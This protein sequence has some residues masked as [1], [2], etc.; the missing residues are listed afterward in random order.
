MRRVDEGKHSAFEENKSMFN[1][2]LDQI[3]IHTAVALTLHSC[4]R[5]SS[6]I[7]CAQSD[8]RVISHT[9]T[10]ICSMFRGAYEKCHR[11]TATNTTKH[12]KWTRI[13]RLNRANYVCAIFC[14]LLYMYMGVSVNEE[15]EKNMRNCQGEPFVFRLRTCESQ[16]FCV[17]LFSS[18]QSFCYLVKQMACRSRIRYLNLI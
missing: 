12:E 9:S 5:E 6:C 1:R 2:Q 3:L 7:L 15:I 4:V 10:T 14:S 11:T 17:F 8:D 16:K 13:L 18:T